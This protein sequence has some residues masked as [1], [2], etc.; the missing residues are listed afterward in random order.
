ML[1]AGSYAYLPLERVVFGRPAADAV[2]DE[3]KRVGAA[4]VFIVAAKSVARN[5][6][7]VSAIADA[8]GPR[9]YAGLFDGCVQHS[10][11]E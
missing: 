3:M 2:V 6:P 4:K 9:H 7:V 10:P 8:L 5:T 1:Q 11:R